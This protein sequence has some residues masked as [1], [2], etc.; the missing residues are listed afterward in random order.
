MEYLVKRG[1]TIARI[2]ERLNTNWQRLK[3]M[4]PEAVGQTSAT[5]RWFLK[6]GATVR[7]GNEFQKELDQAVT[8]HKAAGVDAPSKP[9]KQFA[10]Y[11]IQKGD[12]LWDLAVRRFHVHVND[13]IRHNH[14][15]NP[16]LIQPDQTIEVPLPDNGPQERTVVASWYGLGYQGKT[17]ANGDDFDMFAS[18]IAHKDLPLGTR[19]ELENPI[20]GER[21][22]AVVTDRGPF[23]KGRNVDL[24]YG[25]ARK[26]SLVKKGVGNL[27]MRILG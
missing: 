23:V 26:L 22:Q 2:T 24:S 12:T 18:T 20:T 25:L 13:L 14:I 17:M 27:L 16:R 3:Q 11:T 19:V 4:N 21:A 7:S 8:A 15:D 5:K 9:S 6:E 10:K 1:D